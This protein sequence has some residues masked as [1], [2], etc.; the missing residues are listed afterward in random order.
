MATTRTRG[1]A[2]ATPP[3]AAKSG[4]QPPVAEKNGRL[5]ALV[6]A[7]AA[8]LA[9]V[10]VLVWVSTRGDEPQSAATAPAAEGGPFVG[11]DLHAAAT[12]GTRLFV[13]GHQGAARSDRGGEWTAIPTLADEDGMAW[14]VT[15][16]AVLVGGHGG[17][18]RSTDKGA[19]FARVDGLPV[20]DVHALGAAEDRVYLA[21]PEAGVLVS[22]DA[23]RSWT[24][25][26]QAGKTFM[27]SMLVDPADPEHVLAPDMAQG[28][29]ESRDAGRSWRVLGG[30]RGAMTLAWDSRRRADIV[31][32]GMDGA[33]TSSDGGATWRALAVPAGTS[34]LAF[35]D[36]SRLV[37]GVLEGDRARLFTSTDQGASWS[38]R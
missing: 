20:S 22:A 13:S 8:V 17:L 7:L 15:Q 19:T 2:R 4:V 34:A 26:S 25:A 32:V 16:A 36:A 28:V 38:P 29:V 18:Y 33:A 3:R 9:L 31:A 11:G 5:V 27:G 10:G 1:A 37:A 23:G 14:T 35:D 6:V 24:R 21:S 30:V 12:M